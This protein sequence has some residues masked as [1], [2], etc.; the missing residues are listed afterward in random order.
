[1]VNA[2]IFD[3]D[4]TLVDSVDLHAR[5][6]QEALAHF[7]HRLPY[8]RIR[9]QIGKGGDQLIPAL[10]PPDEA[11][12][13]G[14]TL[15]DYRSD[16]YKRVF[17]PRVRA[18]PHV[19]DLFLRLRDDGVRTALASSAKGEELAAY[20]RIAQIED[21]LSAETSADDA[22]R[23]KPYPDIFAAALSR[24]VGADADHSVVVGDSPYD[25]QA[26]R[27]LGLRTLGV[28]SGGF[29][30]AELKRAG[31]V[32]LYEDPADLLARYN[33]WR[34]AMPPVRAERYSPSA[35]HR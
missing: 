7:G 26:A 14:P 23:S 25:V 29:T 33:S 16:L 12:R 3:I 1:M 30:A 32:G 18:F 19:R 20:K 13:I 2:V 34:S 35:W 11:R 4:G 6:W 17:L 8:D 27:K 22:D 15:E 5:A 9:G 31:A 24:L 28:L 21:L 10:L